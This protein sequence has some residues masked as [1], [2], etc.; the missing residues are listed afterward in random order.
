M[1]YFVYILAT[2]RNGTLYVGSTSN[3]IKRTWEHKQKLVDGFTKRYD[4]NQLVYYE[5]F[6][7]AAAMVARERQLKQWNRLWKL[8]L[9]EAANPDWNDL[10][11]TII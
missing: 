7:S 3:L 6:D 2:S 10:Y 8:K 11:P 5:T 1:K 4:I 9:I